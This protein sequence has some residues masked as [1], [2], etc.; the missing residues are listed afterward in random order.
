[1]NVSIRNLGLLM[2]ISCLRRA[3]FW[4]DSNENRFLLKIVQISIFLGISTKK[5]RIFFI[6][7]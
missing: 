4:I 2:E 3:L 7:I 6:D 5:L 1:M